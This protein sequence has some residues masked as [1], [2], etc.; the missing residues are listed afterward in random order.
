MNL[1]SKLK[2]G[3]LQLLHNDKQLFSTTRN[4][5]N[6]ARVKAVVDDNL[7]CN[8][9]TRKYVECQPAR[10]KKDEQAI[11]DILTCLIEFEADPF[12]EFTLHS[13]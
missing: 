12:Y 5:N 1:N 7:K 11:Q 6:V 4:V 13:L 2:S 9:W 3:W 8:Y 10:M